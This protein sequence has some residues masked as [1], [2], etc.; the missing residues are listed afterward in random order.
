MF[1][2]RAKQ[3]LTWVSTK[4]K[5]ITFFSAILLEEVMRANVLRLSSQEARGLKDSEG[6]GKIFFLVVL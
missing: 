5:R 4:M 2:D 1:P 6:E 3:L